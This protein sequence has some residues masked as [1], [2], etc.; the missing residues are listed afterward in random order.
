MSGDWRN[1]SEAHYS[2]MR[3]HLVM[4]HEIPVP[5]GIKEDVEKYQQVQQVSRNTTETI[6]RESTGTG[7][8]AD[9]KTQFAIRNPDWT[10]EH[11]KDLAEAAYYIQLAALKFQNLAVQEIVAT[12][13]VANYQSGGDAEATAKALEPLTVRTTAG[14][15]A[16]GLNYAK[17]IDEARKL[18]MERGKKRRMAR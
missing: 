12:Y 3:D 5:S 18:K 14:E 11:S 16:P 10:E 4:K 13:A 1:D 6:Y 7:D 9:I 15:P 8:T 17:L 2:L